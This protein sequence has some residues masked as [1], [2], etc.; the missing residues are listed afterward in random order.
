MS[1]NGST[2][3]TADWLSVYHPSVRVI[4]TT[5]PVSFARA[6]NAGILAARFTRTLLLNNDMIVQPHDF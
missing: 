4:R 3:N 2:D 6:V 1:D 5:A